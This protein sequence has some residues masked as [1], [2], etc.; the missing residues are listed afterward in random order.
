MATLLLE[1]L[2]HE[3][4]SLLAQNPFAK[5]GNLMPAGLVAISPFPNMDAG[6]RSA[7]FGKDKFF[8]DREKI[9]I[10]TKNYK[11]S[12]EEEL[13][14]QSSMPAPPN[15]RVDSGH[16]DIDQM[17][18]EN[19]PVD[20]FSSTVD[21]SHWNVKN[22]NFVR[23]ETTGSDIF[24]GDAIRWARDRAHTK[25]CLH[26]K[27][28]AKYEEEIND[29]ANGTNG[30][31]GSMISNDGAME[32]CNDEYNNGDL[33]MSINRQTSMGQ[34]SFDGKNYNYDSPRTVA[35]KYGS[36]LY[37]NNGIYSTPSGYSFPVDNH[38]NKEFQK[39][40]EQEVIN[41][42]EAKGIN[43]SATG[44]D[45]TGT[46]E[47]NIQSPHTDK[48]SKNSMY[49]SI[50]HDTGAGSSTDSH[51][52][53]QNFLNARGR[54]FLSRPDLD[55]SYISPVFGDYTGLETP[56]YI[57]GGAKETLMD[58][59]IDYAY[60][61]RY[62]WGKAKEDRERKEREEM[63]Y[64]GGE[65]GYVG[66]EKSKR[67]QGITLHIDADMIH[68]HIPFMLP[69]GYPHSIHTLGRLDEWLRRV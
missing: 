11:D 5:V 27:Q 22:V 68:A 7:V 34:W 61:L 36:S 25:H 52:A 32:I 69:N 26:K 19:F 54:A 3:K 42:L 58:E 6:G 37:D 45:N 43:L 2:L 15:N 30:I 39:F 48:S 46:N 21:L 47:E 65:T 51:P 38:A 20:Q 1:S 28:K 57:T 33:G 16:H 13:Q 60:V 53:L 50:N 23:A 18:I 14:S 44:I 9:R 62:Y 56:I 55:P 67:P 24:N 64:V 59:I 49:S 8:Y 10:A 66:G 12:K 29:L 40:L 63:G 4:R 31:N 35:N 41:E 17:Q